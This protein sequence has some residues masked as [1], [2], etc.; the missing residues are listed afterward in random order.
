MHRVV[1]LA[2]PVAL[3][4]VIVL[5]A[6]SGAHARVR[7]T[8]T[9]V[10]VKTSSAQM[11]VD[12]RGMTLYVFAPDRKNKSVCYGTCAVYWPPVI[13]P[14]GTTVPPTLPGLKGTFGVSVRT[15]GK[16][17][18]TYDGAPLYTFIKDKQPG[19]MTGQ[20]L[21]VVGGYW[22]VVVAPRS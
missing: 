18:L 5:G 10:P 12:G 15:D 1:R 19:A 8:A 3:A 13:V 6:A 2:G 20:G 7:S 17:Q 4:G 16:R 11:L 22:W 21:D 9:A 14:K